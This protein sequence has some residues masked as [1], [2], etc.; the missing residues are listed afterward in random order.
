MYLVLICVKIIKLKTQKQIFLTFFLIFFSQVFSQAQSEFIGT[1]KLND[2]SFIS[3]RLHIVDTG[4]KLYGYSITDI[5]GNFETKS[6]ITGNYNRKTGAFDFKE[7]GII[8][9]KSVVDKYDFCFVN[10][11]G[12]LPSLSGTKTFKGKF[13]G[14]YSDGKECISGDIEMSSL[15]K[16]VKKAVTVD[17]KIQKMKQVSAEKK[18]RISVAKSIDTLSMNVLKESQNMSLFTKDQVIRIEV[19]DSGR[20]DG[21]RISIFAN[22]RRVLDNYTV[23]NQHKTIEVPI[24]AQETEIEIMAENEG[25]APPNTAHIQIRDSENE[26][27]T[28]TKL[29]KGK[30][31]K[32]TIL[33]KA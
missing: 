26:I 6:N 24:T 25:D 20:E 31:T 15:Q 5:G 2:T 12:K 33:K 14:L 21:D 19:Y 28:I 30:R 18:A 8:Y 13:K 17:K 23:L 16:L 11:K 10:F 7:S 1:L 9:T 22:K 29:K 32:I 3:Y 4:G 27:Q